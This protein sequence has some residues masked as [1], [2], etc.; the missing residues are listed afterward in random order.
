MVALVEMRPLRLRTLW[1]SHVGRPDN[2]EGS[3]SG[4]VCL[5][6]PGVQESLAC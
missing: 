2:K 4:Q 1:S 6:R 3:M 5:A